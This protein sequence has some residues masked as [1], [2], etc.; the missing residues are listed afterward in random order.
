VDPDAQTAY[1]GNVTVA[2]VTEQ[3]Y[4]PV[5][6]LTENS[7][8]D[9]G[10]STSTL[11]A[12]SV[13]LDGTRVALGADNG[14]VKVY[15]LE[16]GV[17]TL[18]KEYTKSTSF[19]TQVCL[20]DAGTRLFVSD[21]NDN[22]NT[23]KVYVYDYSGS[24]WGNSETH[25]WVSPDGNANDYFGGV[26]GKGI[27]CNSDGTRLL[28][29]TGY[30]GIKK[31]WIFDH[32][33][34]SWNTLA[35]KTWTSSSASWGTTCA[36]NDTGDRAFIGYEAGVDIFHYDGSNWPTSATKNYTGS[37][38]FG[39]SLTINGAGTRL[40]VGDYGYS[41][42]NGQTTLY[43]YTG[44]AWNTLATQVI[45]GSNGNNTYYGHGINMSR[46]GKRYLVSTHNSSTYF[47]NGGYVELMEDTS[48]TGTFSLKQ[49]FESDAASENMGS[50]QFQ[51]GLCL[52]ENGYS[53]VILSTG[54][55][56]SRF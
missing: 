37:S 22:S 41:S 30:V 40:L 10:T 45:N 55:D 51:E 39:M 5:A 43:D 34:S 32:N 21:P 7:E 15:H 48:G 8:I 29:V 16:T 4:D 54:T 17:W 1:F 2:S 49:T 46:D 23:G 11:K 19:G 12:C 20:N 38:N 52:D 31:A 36:L 44:S 33:G 6:D 35:T 27:D 56:V 28:V 13:S 26:A 24:A 3:L 18:K 42:G 14:R 50:Y 25:S 47:S 9:H 53:A